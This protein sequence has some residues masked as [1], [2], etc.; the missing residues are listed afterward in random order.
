MFFNW[1]MLPTSVTFPDSTQINLGIWHF[2]KSTICQRVVAFQKYFAAAAAT[3][4]TIFCCN[5]YTEKLTSRV[6]KS[7]H[8]LSLPLLRTLFL[9]SVRSLFFSLAISLVAALF[10]LC[11]WTR[12]VAG[13]ERVQ[14]RK[15]NMARA[16]SV[17]AE[18]RRLWMAF[19]EIFM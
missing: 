12:G 6:V 16:A 13:H 18:W 8:V 7:C 3:T 14:G 15:R 2:G 1:T 10:P 17:S 5:V 9:S 19:N 11:V 4:R